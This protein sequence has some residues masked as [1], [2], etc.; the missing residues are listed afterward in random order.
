MRSLERPGVF[1]TSWG[2]ETGCADGKELAWYLREHLLRTTR[3]GDEMTRYLLT[4][5]TEYCNFRKIQKLTKAAKFILHMWYIMNVCDQQKEL[6]ESLMSPEN[7]YHSPKDQL[8]NSLCAT[9]KLFVYLSA[10]LYFHTWFFWR[11]GDGGA[12][13][14]ECNLSPIF[15]IPIQFLGLGLWE[16]SANYRLAHPLGNPGSTTGKSTGIIASRGGWSTT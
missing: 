15:F 6:I 1:V 12:C 7:L 14:Q 2:F 8:R 11:I 3:R 5:I 16:N 9:S 4:S 13:R 10:F